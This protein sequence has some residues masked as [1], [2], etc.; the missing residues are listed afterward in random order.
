MVC[1]FDMKEYCP[2]E[3]SYEKSNIKWQLRKSSPSLIALQASTVPFSSLRPSPKSGGNYVT[4]GGIFKKA[5]MRTP[6]ITT[7][8]KCL[9][10]Y[11]VINNYSKLEVN[12]MSLN[13]TITARL[14]E[15]E[16]TVTSICF[17]FATLKLVYN[18][19]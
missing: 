12:K 1:S 16:T 7:R 17:F 5:A 3:H 11:Y 10:F 15:K 4:I 19:A 14:F 8:S 2:L 6:V 18:K 9:S 13:G